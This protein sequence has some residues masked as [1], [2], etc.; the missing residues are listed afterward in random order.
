MTDSTAYHLS[1]LF[2][3]ALQ[4]MVANRQAVNRLDGYNGNHGDNMIENLGI[5]ADARKTRK[6]TR[7]PK[8]CDMRAASSRR[9][10]AAAPAS[11]TR[12]G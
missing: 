4:A 2:R 8:R 1:S 9:E 7:P 3:N 10:A 12:E 6:G 5:V 11:T